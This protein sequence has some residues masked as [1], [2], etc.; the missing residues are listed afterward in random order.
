MVLCLLVAYCYQVLEIN[1]IPRVFHL[2]RI[3][4]WMDGQIGRQADGQLDRQTDKQMTNRQTD[5]QMT[6]HIDGGLP[7]DIKIYQQTKQYQV[8]LG[9]NVDIVLNNLQ[10]LGHQHRSQQENSS[11]LSL[12]P[13][14]DLFYQVDFLYDLSPVGLLNWDDLLVAEI[15]HRFL[16]YYT[17]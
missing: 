5:R 7:T 6:R 15:N 13:F 11:C 2:C 12:D 14:L 3:D 9:L 4:G 8:S 17:R 10:C 16:T 1:Q